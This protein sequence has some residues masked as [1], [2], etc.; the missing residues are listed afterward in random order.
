MLPTRA[1]ILEHGVDA[2]I[3]SCAGVAELD[4]TSIDS[5]GAAVGGCSRP[6]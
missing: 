6:T 4:L 1:E 2:G 3:P 5:D